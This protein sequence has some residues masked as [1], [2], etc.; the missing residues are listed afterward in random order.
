M[1]AHE[2]ESLSD[3]GDRYGVTSHVMGRWLA[4][5]DVRTVGAGPTSRAFELG[6]VKEVPHGRG[7]GCFWVWHVTKVTALLTQAGHA[8]IKGL[9]P[10]GAV[11]GMT[12]IDR[13]DNPLAGPFDRIQSGD[14]WLIVNR[15]GRTILWS[16]DGGVA[17]TVLKLLQLAYR[18]KA[19]C[20]DND[21][22]EGAA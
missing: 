12:A 13:N 9:D 3:L 20:L 16:M 2:F 21:W 19:R 14:G 1:N 15:D 17:D 7:D 5:L 10:A 22:T 11:Q 6:L 18:H 4:A 8:L